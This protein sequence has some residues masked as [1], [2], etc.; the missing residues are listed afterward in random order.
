ML[1]SSLL[2]TQGKKTRH[3]ASRIHMTTSRAF[4]NSEERPRHDG[5][6]NFVIVWHDRLNQELLHPASSGT[7]AASRSKILLIFIHTIGQFRRYKR[8]YYTKLQQYDICNCQYISCCTPSLIPTDKK[9]ERQ[10]ES[11]KTSE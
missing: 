9:H 5:K 4:G 1:H 11:K 7:F 10:E 2:Y 8:H 6:S 3:E